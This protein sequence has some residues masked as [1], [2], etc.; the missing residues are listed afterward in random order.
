VSEQGCYLVSEAEIAKLEKVVFTPKGLNRDCVGKSAEVILEMIGVKP[1]AKIRCIVFKGVKEHP[2]IAEELMMPILGMVT[3]K[4]FTAG[5]ETA[6]WLE[7]GYRHS[8]HIHST[9]VYRLRE[10][11]K[12]VNTTI[13]VKNAP[14]YAGIGFGG[15][16]FCT[17]TIASRTGEGL[18][19]ASTFTKKRRIVLAE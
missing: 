18:T 6:V 9:N 10:Y 2:L 17:F 5:M 7:H 11:T 8:A 16:G 15:E 19:S 12:E 1:S 14:S 3:A 13:V 4:D